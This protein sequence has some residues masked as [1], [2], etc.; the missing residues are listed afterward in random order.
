MAAEVAPIVEQYST[1]VAGHTTYRLKARLTGDAY[2]LHSVY[3]NAANNMVIPA[4]YQ[5]DPSYGGVDVGGVNPLFYEPGNQFGPA[6]ATSEFDS[7]L[8][9]DEDLDNDG[10]P[11]NLGLASLTTFGMTT[12][13]TAWSDTAE[14]TIVDGAV[15]FFSQESGV[16]GESPDSPGQRT[17]GNDRDVYVAQLTVHDSVAHTTTATLNFQGHTQSRD[18]ET[19]QAGTVTADW[20]AT[21]I[22]FRM[23]NDPAP[24][25]LEP[26]SSTLEACIAS[27]R[28]GSELY[29]G[30]PRSDGMVD[31]HDVLAFLAKFR[32]QPGECGAFDIA[33]DVG[34]GVA[35][36]LAVLSAFRILCPRAEVRAGHRD[37]CF[38]LF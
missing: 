13:L 6:F 14:L 26:R 4:A 35:D 38:E 9:I 34:V 25:R 3:G 19:M 28:A 10:E 37:A 18:D 31:V 12:Q 16:E 27:D 8:T 22:A 11:D 23:R 15:I 7:W 33:G 32:C 5:V 36:I 1:V 17:D 21:G 29:Q 2:N 24:I 30:L 20:S